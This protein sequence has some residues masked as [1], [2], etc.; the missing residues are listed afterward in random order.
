MERQ[1]GHS[2]IR[3]EGEFT[4][5]SAAELKTLLLEGLASRRDLWLDLERAEGIDIT[6][7][8]LLWAAG[9]EAD[10]MGARI[11]IRVSEAAASDA[12]NAGFE[13]FPGEAL[14]G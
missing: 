9:R 5:T 3:L 1:E 7:M 13:R 8:Q 10:R 14:R 4:L 12:R 11:A 2:L 6:A